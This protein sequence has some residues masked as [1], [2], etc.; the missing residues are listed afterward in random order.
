M[1]RHQ[2]DTVAAQEENRPGEA[3]PSATFQ[4]QNRKVK[5]FDR[6]LRESGFP[7]GMLV[8]VLLIIAFIVM[9]V[10]VF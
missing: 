8:V 9:A 6:P 7:V 1:E 4:N 2:S 10:Y 5:M 3:G